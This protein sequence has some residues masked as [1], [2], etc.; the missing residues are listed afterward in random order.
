[1]NQLLRASLAA[2]T[3][4]AAATAQ[5][6]WA[7]GSP[8]SRPWQLWG[9]EQQLFTSSNN[10][11]AQHV[12]NAN[13][14]PNLLV[15]APTYIDLVWMYEGVSN[16]DHAFGYFVYTED[17][18]VLDIVD[19]QLMFRSVD[20]NTSTWT[21]S[22]NG[23]LIPEAAYYLRDGDG[24]RRLFQPGDRIGFFLVHDG[25][26]QWGASGPYA[27]I[28]Q[29]GEPGQPLIPS[30]DYAV[31]D[32]FG[33]TGGGCL[34]SLVRFN[35]GAPRQYDA[36]G[37]LLNAGDF[38]YLAM[39]HITAPQ[40][41]F[42]NWLGGREYFYCG[43]EDAKS[44]NS[45]MDWNEFVFQVSPTV[46]G[47]LDTAANHG[48]SG[49]PDSDGDGVLN[50]NDHYPD[51]PDRAFRRREP[52]VGYTVLGMEDNYP[53]IGDADYNDA[54]LAYAFEIVTDANNQI[55]DT[56]G[57][58]HLI[59]RGAAFDAA[60]GL[61]IPD[62][63]QSVTG[64]VT[65]ERYASGAGGAAPLTSQ[66][67]SSLPY[68]LGRRIDDLFPST[69]DAL[70]PEPGSFATNTLISGKVVEPASC[71][72]RWSFD[73]PV[74]PVAIGLAPYDL[75][76]MVDIGN[77]VYDVHRPGFAAFGGRP[78]WLPNESGPGSFL[79][80]N[81]APWVF[82]VGTDWRFPL[83][84]VGIGSVYSRFGSWVTSAGG[85]DADWYRYVTPGQESFV[86][87]EIST[88]VTPRAWSLLVR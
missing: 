2:S 62:L 37:A 14:S 64:T 25:G 80:A 85:V 7:G 22:G 46:A 8:W 51:D 69:R 63:P 88:F 84:T 79:D 68:E 61:R 77:A 4:V 21:S 6:Y 31:N 20:F 87:D 12:S 48:Y 44:P 18:G 45:S 1:M 78:S 34:T 35:P 28:F 56:V 11:A 13:Y 86:S 65:Y 54:V 9:L 41:R 16:E 55:R 73:Q 33:A 60:V 76:F 50:I 57:M 74:D 10:Q 43:F 52:N 42:P 67:L 26:E 58:F 15:Q 19:R 5:D 24:N 75:F 59:A 47:A 81:G 36:N 70:P 66:S 30:T 83:E 72:V 49:D 38:K 17:N 39:T 29:W 3:I 53:S 32:A 71:A 40:Y 23:Q 82:E 27:P